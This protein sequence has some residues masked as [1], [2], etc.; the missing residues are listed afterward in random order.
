MDSFVYN[1]LPSRVVFGSGTLSRLR[2]EVATLGCSRALILATPQQKDVAEQTA[3]SLKEFAV[4]VFAGATMHTP[5]EVTERALSLLSESNADCVVAFGGGSTVGLGKALALRTGLP[6]I[7]IPTTYA[8]SE[9]TPIL[10]Q[11]EG[12]RKTTVRSTEVLPE[13]VIY[14]VSLTMSLPVT[15]SVVSGLNAMAHAVEALYAQDRNPIHSLMAVEAIRSLRSALPKIVTA[16]G[17]E[18]ARFQALYG[19][20]LCGVCLGAVGMGLHHKL[21][22]VLGGAFDL[23]HAETHAVV[24]P[25]AVSYNAPAEPC[26][27]REIAAAL[28]V[29]D[30]VRGLT[31]L[32]SKLGAP[33]SLR[34]LGMPEGGIE[35][36]VDQIVENPYWNP[37]PIERDAIRELLANAWAGAPPDAH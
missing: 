11:T 31:D 20:W 14:D 15:L 24:L 36:A 23:P 5:V 16:P 37:R 17:N 34:E 29:T 9:M 18:E 22:H 7:A 30:P 2:D 8:G 1:G 6:Q 19:A 27:M 12:G 21:C 28:G 4:G 33:H 13:V 26:V 10:G 3:A 32:S 35:Q 25:Y